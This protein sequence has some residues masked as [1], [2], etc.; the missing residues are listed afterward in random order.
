MVRYIIRRLLIA[1]PVVFLV[2]LATFVLYTIGL[3]LVY[4][5]FDPLGRK[6]EPPGVSA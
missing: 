4:L 2:I 6:A 5:F 3:S 1:I